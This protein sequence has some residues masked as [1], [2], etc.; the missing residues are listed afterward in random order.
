M[1]NEAIVRPGR[2]NAVHNVLTPLYFRGGI[3]YSQLL[4]R[5]HRYRE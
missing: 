3:G 5:G 1:G 4:S 2:T